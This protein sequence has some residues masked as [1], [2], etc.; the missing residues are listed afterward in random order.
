M[1][2]I[3]TMLANNTNIAN[4]ANYMRDAN[5]INDTQRTININI[6]IAVKLHLCYNILKF[7]I[8]V[9]FLF[10]CTCLSSA[11]VS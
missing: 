10:Q 8:N 6:Y 5:D 1:E 7:L 4:D 3:E 11:Q 9:Y 2:T